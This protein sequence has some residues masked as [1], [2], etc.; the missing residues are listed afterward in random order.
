M[1]LCELCLSFV[2]ADQLCAVTPVELNRIHR[3]LRIDERKTACETCLKELRC[4][5]KSLDKWQE[6]IEISAV[7]NIDGGRLS[8]QDATPGHHQ[9]PDLIECHSCNAAPFA[10]Q[11][12]LHSHEMMNHRCFHCSAIFPD[13]RQLQSHSTACLKE[14][15]FECPICRLRFECES[16]LSGHV[17]DAHEDSLDTVEC[18]ECGALF[19]S[20]AALCRHWRVHCDDNGKRQNENKDGEGDVDTE[21]PLHKK[22]KSGRNV[23]SQ[24]G[25][26]TYSRVALSEVDQT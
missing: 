25:L 15:R 21:S 4:V 7:E 19:A 18:R 17:T 6:R 26:K 8:K 10:S 13:K 22:I 1:P 24:S 20:P 12:L 16:R 14:M 3:R 23:S 2:A 11:S 9:S 5:A